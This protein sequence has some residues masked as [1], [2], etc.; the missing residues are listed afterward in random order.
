MGELPVVYGPPAEGLS[1]AVR[2]LDNRICSQDKHW[3]KHQDDTWGV[4]WDCAMG[5][6]LGLSHAPLITAT[7]LNLERGTVFMNM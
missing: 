5:C 1:L 2:L 7:K 3:G 6:P 4:H